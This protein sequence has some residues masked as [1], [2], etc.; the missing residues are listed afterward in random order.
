MIE[1]TC[2]CVVDLVISQHTSDWEMNQAN[3]GDI[4]YIG[5]SIW[6]SHTEARLVQPFTNK[7][8][9]PSAE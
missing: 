8:K 3:K 4:G 9:D 7:P 1:G 5:N 2:F 6:K